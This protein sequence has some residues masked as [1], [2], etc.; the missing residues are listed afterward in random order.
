M[1]LYT[2]LPSS[3]EV[4]IPLRFVSIV[5]EPLSGEIVVNTSVS[6]S[7]PDLVEGFLEAV[8]EAIV[9]PHCVQTGNSFVLIERNQNLISEW[10]PFCVSIFGLAPAKVDGQVEP[11]QLTAATNFK[12]KTFTFRRCYTYEIRPF[13]IP[14]IEEV[15]IPC[16][17][18]DQTLPSQSQP[19]GNPFLFNIGKQESCQEVKE[20]LLAATGLKEKD[21]EFK[22]YNSRMSS[23]P[24]FTVPFHDY[25]SGTPKSKH[26]PTHAMLDCKEPEEKSPSKPDVQ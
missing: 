15:T 5:G 16:G 21:P 14:K 13:I 23:L 4:P 11:S 25:I 24:D 10:R 1:Y 2:L 7:R 20:R 18:G 17:F 19:H 26:Y 9:K 22:I 3:V 12:L 6:A 8:G